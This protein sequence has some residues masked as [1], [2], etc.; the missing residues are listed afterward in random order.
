MAREEGFAYAPT[1]QDCLLDLRKQER[2]A[3]DAYYR[4]KTITSERLEAIMDR[5]RHEGNALVKA[6]RVRNKIPLHFTDRMDW[7]LRRRHGSNKSA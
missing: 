4:R 7:L 1:E 3:L 6:A 5:M 2:D